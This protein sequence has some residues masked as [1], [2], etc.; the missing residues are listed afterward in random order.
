MAGFGMGSFFSAVWVYMFF[1]KYT[2][3]LTAVFFQEKTRERHL[4]FMQAVS[5]IL[6]LYTWEYKTEPVVQS[7]N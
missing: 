2:H 7:L 6:I 1:S 3:T 5:Y 4:C